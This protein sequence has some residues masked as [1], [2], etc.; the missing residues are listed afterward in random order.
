MSPF[1]LQA[2]ATP[3]VPNM[4]KVQIIPPAKDVD[5]RV[6]AWKGAA[7][8]GKMDGVSDLWLSAADWVSLCDLGGLPDDNLKFLTGRIGYTWLERKVFLFV[9]ASLHMYITG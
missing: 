8:L 2:I 3:L 1:R 5:Q 9:K 7:V 4:E 6:L